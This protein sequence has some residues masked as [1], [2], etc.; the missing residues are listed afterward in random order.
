[1]K[2]YGIRLQILLMGLGLTTLSGC[3]VAST[4]PIAEL[5]CDCFTKI[6]P[7]TTVEIPVKLTQG[8]ESKDKREYT[9][10]V[11]PEVSGL[12]FNL[13]PNKIHFEDTSMLQ[14]TTASNITPGNYDFTVRATADGG[15]FY[16]NRSLLII[17][18][19]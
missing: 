3:F 14:V 8:G 12:S 10:S 6:K 7:S 18:Q 17:A 5:S 16:F 15:V 2:Y 9:L 11:V 19:P 4:L 1:M 13:I